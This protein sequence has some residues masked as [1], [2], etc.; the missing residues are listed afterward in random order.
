MIYITSDFHFNHQKE[1]IYEP[2]GFHSPEEMNEVLL[3]N[4]NSIVKP[5]DEV[6]ILGDLMLGGAV[7]H[8]Q[9]LELISSLNG[10]LHL[11]RG[12]HDTDLRWA[13]YSK[14]DNVVECENAIYLNYKKYH[15]YLSHYPSMTS[16]YT[17]EKSLKSRTLNLCGHSHTKDIWLHWMT[18]SYHCEVDA[19]DNKPVSIDEIIDDMKSYEAEQKQKD[20]DAL[21]AEVINLANTNYPRCDKC[22]YDFISCRDN[23]KDGKCKTYKRDPPDGGYYG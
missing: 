17:D 21:M 19:H 6:Y 3:E 4:Y 23:D 11:V 20:F 1:F 5:E 12:N 16:N 7:F 14:L 22:V 18:G 10:H 8:R 2:R 13:A 9:G 15:F